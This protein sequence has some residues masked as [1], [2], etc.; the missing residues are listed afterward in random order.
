VI[1][2]EKLESGLPTSGPRIGPPEHEA[3][4]L[5]ITSWLPVQNL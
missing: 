1:N 3:G 4:M 5:T 2:H